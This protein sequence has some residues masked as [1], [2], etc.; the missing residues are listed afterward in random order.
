M[1]KNFE[2]GEM[3]LESYP[4]QHYVIMK[5]DDGS[6]KTILM[7]GIDI[8]KLYQSYNLD[9]PYHFCEYGYS[10]THNPAIHPDN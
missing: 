5:Y 7:N 4:C 3:C 8:Y 10:S 6:S 2:V 9:I 1:I